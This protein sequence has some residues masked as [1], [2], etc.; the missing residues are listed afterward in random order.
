MGI[1]RKRRRVS[2]GNEDEMI[3]VENIV[4]VRKKKKKK[5]K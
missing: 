2:E 5:K 3:E 1:I 4:S